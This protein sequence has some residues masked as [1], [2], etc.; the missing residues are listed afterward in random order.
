MIAIDKLPLYNISFFRE[1]I[2]YNKL[3]GLLAYSFGT[4]PYHRY[5]GI[6]PE[7][8]EFYSCATAREFHTVPYYLISNLKPNQYAFK[9]QG[10]RYNYLG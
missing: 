3:A 2:V 9:E 6:L 4:F 8:I 7:L 10:R 5:S 1:S